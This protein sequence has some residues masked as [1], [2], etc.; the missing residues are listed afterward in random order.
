M[1]KHEAMDPPVKEMMVETTVADHTIVSLSADVVG[2]LVQ[3][4]ELN[5]GPVPDTICTVMPLA[6]T[7]ATT[8]NLEVLKDT[9]EEAEASTTIA[10]V[11]SKILISNCFSR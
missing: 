9:L 8:S 7:S 2:S 6:T 4:L 1:S 5:L 11:E 10:R 3:G